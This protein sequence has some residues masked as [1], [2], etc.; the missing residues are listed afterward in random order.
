MTEDQDGYILT[1]DFSSEDD[2][3]EN[4]ESDEGFENL[5]DEQVSPTSKLPNPRHRLGFR[6]KKQSER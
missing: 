5:S 2:K 1:E 6:S 4:E 3:E